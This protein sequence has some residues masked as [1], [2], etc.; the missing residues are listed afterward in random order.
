MPVKTTW[1]PADADGKVS[2]KEKND[3]PNSAFVF[4][5]QRK[6][7]VTDASHLRNALARFNQ[8]EGVTD[9][10]REVAFANL[11]KAAAHFEVDM[12]EN[13]WH[14]LGKHPHSNKK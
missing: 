7:P 6:E 2:A 11:K 4:P 8:V 3:L 13:S 5:K 1:K 12:K 9:E 10:D 14:E